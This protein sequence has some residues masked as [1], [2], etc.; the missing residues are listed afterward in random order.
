MA[1]L[2][3]CF[4]RSKRDVPL[5]PIQDYPPKDWIQLELNDLHKGN[6]CSYQNSTSLI[7]LDGCVCHNRN[8]VDHFSSSVVDPYFINLLATNI[9]SCVMCCLLTTGHLSIEL[10]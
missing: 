8:P 1:L 4:D 7:K 6:S 9:W 3:H 2:L 10:E 5:C